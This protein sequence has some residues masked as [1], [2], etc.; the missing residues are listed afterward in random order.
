MRWQD[1]FERKRSLDATE[2]KNITELRAEGRL[3]SCSPTIFCSKVKIGKKF[4]PQR[5]AKN[6]G[7]KHFYT[8]HSR[9][10][11]KR[12]KS[13][14]W[15]L[16]KQLHVLTLTHLCSLTHS[17]N[18]THAR[19]ITYTLSLPHTFVSL[20]FSFSLMLTRP[21]VFFLSPYG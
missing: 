14:S 10:S 6:I 12:E 13:D 19:T 17:H 3:S 4:E 9:P 16:N 7:W 8:F 11:C 15:N 18:R 5:R 21:L 20:S 1:F 2:Q